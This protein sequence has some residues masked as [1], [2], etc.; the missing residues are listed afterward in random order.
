[1]NQ[2][3]TTSSVD[4]TIPSSSPTSKQEEPQ[5]TLWQATKSFWKDF[6]SFRG[7]VDRTQFWLSFVMMLIITS[8]LQALYILIDAIYSLF[9]LSDGNFLSIIRFYQFQQVSGSIYGIISLILLCVFYVGFYL[10][11]IRRL[12]DIN[13]SGYWMLF[14]LIPLP[15]LLLTILI[16]TDLLLAYFTII[17][18]LII[19]IGLLYFFVQASD[20]N[21]AYGAP[22]ANAAIQGDSNTLTIKGILREYW[23]KD[24]LQ[25]KPPVSRGFYAVSSISLYILTMVLFLAFSAIGSSLLTLTSGSRIAVYITIFLLGITGIAFSVLSLLLTIRRLHSAGWRAWWILLPLIP[26]CLTLFMMVIQSTALAFF[27]N[28]IQS[29]ILIFYLYVLSLPVKTK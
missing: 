7:R 21:N 17:I 13:H 2:A 22:P 14:N 18:S 29:V 12:H 15:F 6:F 26:V 27:A 19:E 3:P 25:L 4:M 20:K 10:L 16:P 5:L 8:G 23:N 1:M 24:I 28:C 11:G 9:F